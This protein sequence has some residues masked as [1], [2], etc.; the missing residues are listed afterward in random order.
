[1]DS[2]TQTNNLMWT[3]KN[4]V[5][6]LVAYLQGRLVRGPNQTQALQNA[7]WGRTGLNRKHVLQ[8]IVLPFPEYLYEQVREELGE[9]GGNATDNIFSNTLQK[10]TAS[11]P[12]ILCVHR[13]A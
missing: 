7:L 12:S 5:L 9:H 1:M 6:H 13:P 4:L 11:R 10:V 2:H 8:M 3:W